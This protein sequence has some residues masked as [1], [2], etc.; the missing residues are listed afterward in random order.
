MRILLTIALYGV[1]AGLIATRPRADDID[2]YRHG[3]GP[4]GG[5]ARL[6]FAVDL[7]EGAADVLCADAAT[8][9]CE[10]TLG[11]DLYTALDLFG[12]GD[13]GDGGRAAQ[14]S[15][16]GVADA[17]Q[18]DPEDGAQSMAAGHWPGVAVDRYDL[19]RA[20]LA[21]VL[22]KLGGELRGVAPDRRLEVALMALHA[23]HC[24]GAGP[25]YSPDFNRTPVTGCSQ[26]AYVLQGFTDI[27]DPEGLE[28]LLLT[29]AALPDPGRR[30][31]WM[32]APW[33]GHPYKLRDIY[34]ELYRYLSGQAVFN[35]FLG[36]R[37]YSSRAS[38]NL[39][40]S[41]LGKVNNDVLLPLPDGGAPRPLLSPATDI[42]LPASFD[43]ASN[44]VAD[45][46]YISPIGVDEE[47]ASV[48]MVHLR[49]GANSP[50]HP[51]TNAAI[52]A[53]PAEA[54]LGLDL[55]AGE[56]GDRSLIN[57]LAAGLPAV[58]GVA[59]ATGLSLRSYFFALEPDAAT[60]AL[61]LAGGTGRAYSLADPL[62]MVQALEM[63]FADIRGEDS[64]LV[65]GAVPV[66][67]A[68]SSGLVR[69]IYFA[70]FR[71]EPGPLWKGN[72]KKLKIV[73]LTA[74]DP[75][76][77]A[78]SQREVIA[79][80]PLGNPPS[81]AISQEDG[82]ILPDALTFWTDPTGADVLAFDPA[83]QEVSGRDG[84]SITRGGAGQKISGFLS[85]RV[86]A[87][88]DE[89]DARQMYTLDP[90]VPG[91]L[92]ALD[93]SAATF[94]GLR[95]Y[96]DPAGLLSESDGLDI[97]RWIR[98]QDSL[99]AD[100]D[101]DRLESRR[102]LLGD[103]LHSRPLAVNYGARPGTAYSAANPDIR[104]FFGSNDGVFHVLRN[105]WPD[106]AES[107][108]ET[109]AFIPPELL[110]MQSLLAHNDVSVLQSHP[111]GLDGEAVAYIRDRDGNGSIESDRGD[112]V[113]VFIG[114]RR[115]G[116]AIY[117]FDMTDPDKPGYLW[118]IDNTAP[119]FD[120]LA[121]SFSTPRIASLDLGEATPTPALVF[122][123]GYNGGWQG[124]ARIGK[125]AGGDSDLIGNAIYVV[126]PQTGA[127]IWRAVGPAGGAPPEPGAE[128]LF[129]PGLLD[130]IPSP[131]TL[132]DSDHNGVDDRAYVGDSGGNVWRID[133]TEYRKRKPD[134]VAT[135]P[136]NWRMTRL[137]ALGG[138]G[139]A[140][141]R[142]FHAPDVVRSYD[143]LGEYDGVVIVSG[144]RAEP[145]DV[146]VKNY[147]YLL[148]DRQTARDEAL[149]APPVMPEISHDGLADITGACLA[150]A[151]QACNEADLA[152]GWKLALQGR[153]EKG[154]STPLVSNGR[155]LFTS[156]VPFVDD[157]IDGVPEQAVS[158]CE[159]SQG[160]GRIY[161]V[162]LRN[163]SPALTTARKFKLGDA[164]EATRFLS[165]GPGLQ[166]DVVP[167]G[168][169][170][171]I[172]GAGLAEGV[173]VPVPGKTWWRAY[174][175]EDEVDTL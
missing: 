114:Q 95:S 110:G 24:E 74:M 112:L 41:D 36:T 57:L 125:D 76:T 165:I 174:W 42:L 73:S 117:A 171:L 131:V 116:R 50:S 23:D 21:V 22:R 77:G 126:D 86:G 35:G 81:A 44:R 157:G 5:P 12:A 38:G 102:W 18:A 34:L 59:P 16:D 99:D 65:A 120:Q 156:Y 64:S 19:L 97:I 133:F 134:T 128:Q 111:Y 84:R 20:A 94:A 159:S 85:N 98:G 69:D 9:V 138:A 71:A 141:R 121:L 91:E 75:E 162:N 88:N 145:G 167:V 127:L 10:T 39:Y 62:T 104:I 6:V 28:K 78:A 89:P 130:S 108:R 66:N 83:R 1:L 60:D 87:G 2:I 169:G 11:N 93:A 43:L 172:P 150:D 119:G 46:R 153:G 173:L 56:A 90:D 146:Q 148:K 17:L 14:R 61:A 13:N 48:A 175:R 47:C 129:V 3:F 107:G 109:W 122:A 27:S 51:D 80:A 103:P 4:G 168:D 105:T 58:E 32:A 149:P 155:V 163:G 101:D 92:L 63:V 118:T 161:G 152:P 115:G 67:D 82:Q 31:P 26:G 144:N 30:A 160:H 79:Q 54:G 123:G 132:L 139:D 96:L 7:Q 29:L 68:G 45:A 37:D 15:A 124:A 136:A 70:L 55:A 151:A 53:R 25:L 137:S 49:F 147:A 33:P 154:L 100:G 140:D 72:I 135:D 106:A 142:F 8:A 52:A 166:G 170:V 40:H 143:N 113:W 158:T 164:E